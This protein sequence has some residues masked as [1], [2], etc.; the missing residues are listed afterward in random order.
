MIR[1]NSSILILLIIL[2]LL[3]AICIYGVKYT[4]IKEGN[5]ASESVKY[6]ADDHDVS[7]HE[8]TA[9]ILKEGEIAGLAVDTAFVFDPS[10]NK[11]VAIT[12][13]DIVSFP[14]YYTPGTYK[15][16]NPTFVPNYTDSVL[17]SSSREHLVKPNEKLPI[18]Q[19]ATTQPRVSKRS[20]LF[21]PSSIE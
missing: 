16:D 4:S 19:F 13:P 7:Y 8:D 1:L 15:Y 14:T 5:S 10:A 21:N 12:R 6:D 18:F 17:L 11:M 9:E 3:I 2:V 20:T